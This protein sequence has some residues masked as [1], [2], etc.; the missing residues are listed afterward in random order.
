MLTG[1]STTMTQTSGSL[2]QTTAPITSAPTIHAMGLVQIGA[3]RRTATA[4]NSPAAAEATALIMPR[5]CGRSEKPAYIVARVRPI[6]TGSSNRPLSAAS[7]P[8]NSRDPRAEHDR[9][10][11]DVGSRQDLADRQNLREILVAHPVTAGDQFMHD[12]GQDTAK[13]GHADDKEAAEERAEADIWLGRF[14]EFVRVYVT[15]HKPPST[16]I[17]V[18]VT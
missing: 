7:A 12:D 9:Y 18:P 6:A 1:P 3:K 13:A 16:L 8:T 2:N 14:D 17:A 10:V 15:A 5:T 11:D 4:S